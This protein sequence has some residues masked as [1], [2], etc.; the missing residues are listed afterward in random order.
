M[1]T[2]V[3]F[4]R[5]SL[6][7]SS[8]NQIGILLKQRGDLKE[9][10]AS[11]KASR[12]IRQTLAKADP[13]GPVDQI[14]LANDDLE[15]GDIQVLLGQHVEASE[16]FESAIALLDRLNKSNPASLSISLSTECSG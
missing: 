4:V 6:W 10:L 9:A 14:N 1:Q 8:L 15:L 2:P 13:G 7:L 16:S 11:C 12:K 3:S 5:N